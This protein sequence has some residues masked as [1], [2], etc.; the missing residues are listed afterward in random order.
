[1][2]LIATSK[3]NLCTNPRVEEY[4]INL[5]SI[6]CSKSSVAGIFGSNTDTKRSPYES[7]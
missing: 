1:M 2:Q 5:K 3:N 7:I 4:T 6:D